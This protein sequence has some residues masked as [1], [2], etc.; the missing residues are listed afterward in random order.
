[1]QFQGMYCPA[2]RIWRPVTTWSTCFPSGGA[3]A[4]SL[5][6]ACCYACLQVQASKSGTGRVVGFRELGL[7]N[8]FTIEASFCGPCA[9]G[10]WTKPLLVDK[11]FAATLD[12]MIMYCL[13]WLLM[14]RVQ[15]QV[16]LRACISTPAIWNR[17]V[18]CFVPRCV[19][20]GSRL[21]HLESRSSYSSSRFCTRL[22]AAQHLPASSW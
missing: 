9:Y 11:A 8:A 1:M 22:A 19:S 14:H 7:V 13:L 20:I 16:N 4:A 5:S 10:E 17:W 15:S 3:S 12:V 2:C 6:C 18:P 21:R